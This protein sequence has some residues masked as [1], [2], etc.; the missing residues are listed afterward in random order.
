LNFIPIPIFRRCDQL[1]IQ[2]TLVFVLYSEPSLAQSFLFPGASTTF[3]S[4][5]SQTNTRGAAAVASNPANTLLTKRIESY[6]DMTI[7][8]FSYSYQRAGYSPAKIALTAPPVNFGASFK[9]KSNV[10]FGFFFTPRPGLDA[11]KIK[12][13][14]F[15]MDTTVFPVD[16]EQK[17]TNFFTALGGAIKVNKYTAVGLSILEAAED[18][19]LIVRQEGTTSDDD[20]LVGMRYRGISTQFLLGVRTVPNSRMTIAGSLRTSTVRSY[21]GT[22]IIKGD[23]DNIIRKKSFSPMLLAV[24]AERRFGAPAAFGEVK[25]EAWSQG[26]SSSSSGLP[27]ATKQNAFNDL[28]ILIVGGRL[29]LPGG[30]SGSASIGIYPH[31]VGLGS[32][33]EESSSSGAVS[34]VQFG[35]FDALDRTMFSASYRLSRKKLDVTAGFN[36]INGSRSVPEAYPGAGKYTLSVFSV[37][38]GGSYYF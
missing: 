9:P 34:G 17:S 11:M 21:R 7:V 12:S 37:G 23:Q 38:A 27:G 35:E 30:H 4:G 25:Y 19:Q 6:A 15:S 8:N 18:S 3:E 5:L 31:N 29:K 33:T 28:I 14:P 32:V 13:V 22:Q 26:K 2:I 1:A 10:A 24:G 16:I 20:A 36:V